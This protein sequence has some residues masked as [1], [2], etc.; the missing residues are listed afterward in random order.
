MLAYPDCRGKEAIKQVSVYIF[1]VTVTSAK[2]TSESL[3]CCP[4]LGVQSTVMSMSVSQYVCM[5]TYH[6]KNSSGDEIANVNFFYKIAHVEA[7]AYA[8]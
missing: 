4:L 8:H 1:L 7:S 5:L 3:L 2:K 6:N